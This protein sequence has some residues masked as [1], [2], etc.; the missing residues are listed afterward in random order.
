[1]KSATKST[2]EQDI[3]AAFVS[4]IAYHVLCVVP[5]ALLLASCGNPSDIL[6]PRD[7]PDIS[8]TEWDSIQ[9]TYWVYTTNTENALKRT[10]TVTEQPDVA[11][12]KSAMALKEVGGLSI[13]TSEQLVFRD[14]RKNLWHG[15]FCFED[16][17]YLSSSEDSWRSYRF[18]LSSLD[19]YEQLRTLCAANERQYHPEASPKHIKLRRNLA[20]D[21]PKLGAEGIPKRKCE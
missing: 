6:G 3:S 14:G 8:S 21:Y 12:L 4:V 18:V 19:F 9:V 13:G 1:M 17:L 10:F 16:T 7:T 15:D 20:V 2:Q 5:A 11:A